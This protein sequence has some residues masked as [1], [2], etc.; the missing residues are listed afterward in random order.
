M[1]DQ[2]SYLNTDL[3]ILDLTGSSITMSIDGV[4]WTDVRSTV[5]SKYY[6]SNK[7]LTISAVDELSGVKTIQYYIADSV[8]TNQEIEAVSQ[9]QNYSGSIPITS[10]TGVVVYA[11]VTD[12]TN[13]V[14]Y[15]NTDR[16]R[17]GGYQQTSVI[18]GTSTSYS[19][20]VMVSD[21]SSV[22]MY[23]SFSDIASYPNGIS[24]SITFSQVLP[25]NT[26]I[27]IMDRSRSKTYKYKTT[28][29]DTDTILFT[30]FR[31]VGT[32]NHFSESVYTGSISEDYKIIVD[33]SKTE[34]E[35]NITNLSATIS[36]DSILETTGTVDGFNVIRNSDANST[37]ISNYSDTLYYNTD[38]TYSIPITGSLQFATYQTS[39]VIDTTLEDKRFGLACRL[40]DEN[41]NTISKNYLQNIK[42][43][44]DS[45]YFFMDNDG[46]VRMNLGV[47]LGNVN[48]NFVIET[49]S[50]NIELPN[51]TYTF[52]IGY[53]TS[54]D[55]TYSSDITYF[56]DVPVTVADSSYQKMLNFQVRMDDEDRIMDKTSSKQFVVGVLQ[57]SSYSN[58][59]VK[60]RL[61]RKST[62]A[63]ADQTY[64]EIDLADYS[65]A[66][67]T[68]FD[69]NIYNTIITGNQSG[70]RNVSFD[71]NTNTLGSGAYSLAFDLYDGDTYIKSIVK[72]FIIR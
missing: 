64:T 9:W 31:E 60:V 69:E 15:A 45:K 7:T 14:S 67:L 35:S 52:K 12:N 44:I 39:N 49:N 55:G 61:L 23:Y 65:N 4:N 3:L 30:S 17:V 25:E 40:V 53:F 22:S 33:F 58:A 16:L 42:F 19:T 59:N 10:T 66:D 13:Y 68:N 28:S 57:N 63:A 1:N 71:F 47:G 2:V 18:A 26:M 8:L 5:P 50:A 62:F 27:T 56:K 34:L 72:K 32:T 54:F 46:I 6:S 70:Y 37:F 11:K 43:R 20:N 36:I 48:K 29:T 38:A 21:K 51:G 24:H 41:G